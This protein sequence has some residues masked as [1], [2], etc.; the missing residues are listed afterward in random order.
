MSEQFF[1][2][3]LFQFLRELKENN[4]REWFEDNKA[5]YRAEVQDPILEF[6]RA[7]DSHLYDISPNYVADARRSGG[8]MFRIHRDIRFSK[9][10]SPYKT[11]AGIHFRH[12]RGKDAH[13]PGFYLHLEPDNVFGGAGIWCPDSKTLGTIRTAIDED[14]KGWLKARDDRSMGKVWKLY[15]EDSLTRPPR[16]F[17]A[18]HPLID[19]LKLKSITLF[20]S[21]TEKQACRK[22]FLEKYTEA[23]A[24]ARPMMAFLTRSLELEW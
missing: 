12:K 20:T 18:D 2:P 11:A 8:S 21:F 16:G 19:D 9:D 24:M 22:D 6:I 10:K 5:R 17:T 3:K 14:Q 4:N 7:F 13:A 23:A 15:R 1:T